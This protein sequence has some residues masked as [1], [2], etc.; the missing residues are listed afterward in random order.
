MGPGL[1]AIGRFS[2]S[3]GTSGTVTV[4]AGM[5]VVRVT[6]LSVL[7]GSLTI[8]PGG[9]NQPSPVVAGSPI[10][11]QAGTSWSAEWA[12]GLSPLGSGTQFAF[13]STDS[14]YVEYSKATVG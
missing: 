1:V 13:T 4:P 10:P 11:L 14:Y 5:V 6:C 7:G 9:P 2:Y 3:A 12:P 8:A